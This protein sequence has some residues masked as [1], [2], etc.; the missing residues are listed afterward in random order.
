MNLSSVNIAT[1]QGTLSARNAFNRTASSGR[2][3]AE[4]RQNRETI[5]AEGH[6]LRQSD[7]RRMQRDQTEL[8]IRER[9]NALIQKM[10]DRIKDAITSGM[11]DNDK[12]SI[13]QSMLSEIEQIFIRRNEREIQRIKIEMEERKAEIEENRR[14]AEKNRREMREKI[15][16]AAPE[17]KNTE[18][19]LQ[20]EDIYNMVQLSVSLDS[21]NALKQTRARMASSSRHLENELNNSYITIKIDNSEFRQLAREH[22]VKMQELEI[23]KLISESGQNIESLQLKIEN[24]KNREPLYIADT[25]IRINGGFSNPNDFR[26]VQLEKMIGGIAGLDVGINSEIE[27]MNGIAQNWTGNRNK[28]IADS[29]D[30]VEDEEYK[31]NETYEDVK[32]MPQIADADSD[33]GGNVDLSNDLAVSID[34]SV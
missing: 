3:K 10:R 1:S 33:D 11:E 28:I 19:A 34:L 12:K 21:I 22:N 9:E 29:A 17:Y 4:N 13:I 16:E 23:D 2:K 31:L 8:S 7:I 14:E 20:R 15:R 18:E 5:N 25:V 24:I 27:K 26:V 6:Q 32:K 30:D